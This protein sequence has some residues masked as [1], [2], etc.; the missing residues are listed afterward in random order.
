MN[1]Y[2][3]H[4]RVCLILTF[5]VG[6]ILTCGLGPPD[7][8]DEIPVQNQETI[9]PAKIPALQGTTYYVAP[10]P[11]GD[12]SNLGTEAQPWGTI[13]KAANELGPG[14]TV[15]VRAG[16]YQERVIPQNSG[17]EGNYITYAAYP[18]DT[19]TIDGN[20]VSVPVD[21]GLFKVSSKN[22]I[23]ISGLRVINS[24][25]AGILVDY[26][27]HIIIEENYTYNTVSSGIGVWDSNNIVIDGN[28]VELACND[29]E[30]EAI[31]VA[32]T[33][34]FEVKNNHVHHG[35]PG[36]NGGEG[37]DAKDGSRNGKIYNNH[38][39]H[40]N[41]DRTC[42]Y[43][44]S[45]DDHTFN[46]EVYQN[47]L[48]DCGAG[49]SL[50]A[51]AGGLLENIRV[52]NNIAYHNRNN[53]LEIGNWGEP[54]YAHP[55]NDIKFL[56]NTV[57]DNGVSWG[58]GI[59]LENPSAQNVVIR[60]NIFSQNLSFQISNEAGLTGANLT[61]DHNL[62]DGYRGDAGEI[63]G[64]D[65][66]EG[67]PLFVNASGAD[68]HLQGNSPAIDKGSS[69]SAPS[70][71]FDGNVRP[72]DGDNDGTASYDI[73]AYEVGSSIYLTAISPSRAIDPG[74]VVTYTISVGASSGFTDTVSLVAS[75]PSP[76]LT[77]QLVP[78]SVI[79]PGQ[80][81]LTITDSH[82]G[83]AL[84]PGLWYT[85]PIT[86]TDGVTQTT[87]VS[88]LVGGARLY[89]PLILKSY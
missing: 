5:L 60:N 8:G 28:E 23:K 16:T 54:G 67:D 77:L 12:D 47:T 6:L 75:S 39:H 19:V 82:T 88:L 11:T 63:Y 81:T 48:H 85:V 7:S 10:P 78:T 25:D 43:V 46:I 35:G 31:T 41:G 49:V 18:G 61:V 24:T 62:I 38:V 20:G 33:D 27:G 64:S 37:I 83:P 74:D 70:D 73:G 17:S 22:Y 71:D 42:L 55:I 14:D 9:S 15:Y 79:P 52:Y 26:S 32:G 89:L 36:T 72:Q 29:G 58:G 34:T 59:H 40:I 53:G 66:I 13:Q 3:R 1:R 30:Q 68:F 56:N 76:S 50:A 4:P 57:Y 21:E 69:T 44:D 86:A 84:L 45:W 51:E 65:Y 2:R 80:A 87:S